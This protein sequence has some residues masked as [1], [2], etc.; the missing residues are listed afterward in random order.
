[1]YCEKCGRRLNDKARF[2]R[3][4]GSAISTEEK[5]AA[6]KRPHGHR[7]LIIGGAVLLAVVIGLAVTLVIVLGGSDNKKEAGEPAPSAVPSGIISPEPDIPDPSADD[8]LIRYVGESGTELITSGGHAQ[9]R[10]AAFKDADKPNEPSDEY[11]IADILV[12][13]PERVKKLSIESEGGL[14]DAFYELNEIDA[15]DIVSEYAE[16]LNGGNLS[17]TQA[18]SKTFESDEI[19]PLI[20]YEAGYDYIGGGSVKKGLAAGTMLDGSFDVHLTLQIKTGNYCYVH[21]YYPSE[22][23]LI[24]PYASGAEATYSTFDAELGGDYANGAGTHHFFFSGFDKNSYLDLYFA[25][26]SYSTGDLFTWEDLSTAS[27]SALRRADF[28]LGFVRRDPFF[29]DDPSVIYFRFIVKQADGKPYEV[30]GLGCTAESG[31]EQAANGGDRMCAICG[32]DGKARCRG[33]SGL[34]KTRKYNAESRGYVLVTCT[35]CNGS[36]KMTCWRCDGR[37]CID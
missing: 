22:L 30:E 27:Y 31:K 15:L 26:D 25:E 7:T 35:K 2:C 11:G 29:N 16:A 13:E 21:L 24:D 32:G 10:F 14:T 37:G 5:P 33:C 8:G 36:G 23:E 1:M 3:Y 18:L 19:L 20:V 4:C 12:L 28:N 17:C 6:K 34:G 9:F